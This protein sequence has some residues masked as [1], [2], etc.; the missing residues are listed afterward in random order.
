MMSAEKSEYVL[1]SLCLLEGYLADFMASG[2]LWGT[3][4]DARFYHKNVSVEKNE[5]L[6][7]KFYLSMV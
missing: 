5:K 6:I 7:N 2:K 3:R 4:S 1:V